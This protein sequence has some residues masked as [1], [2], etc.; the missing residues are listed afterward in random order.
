MF[1]VNFKFR[2]CVSVLD[3]G[4]NIDV[5]YCDIMKAFDQVPIDRLLRKVKSYGIKGSLLA[6]IG[7]F[8]KNRKMSVVINGDKSSEGSVTSG[9]PQGSIL[10]PLLFT[11][12]IND[13]PIGINSLL[14]MFADDTKL[15]REIKNEDDN[16]YLQQD[17]D[18][19]SDWSEIWKLK[20]HPGKCSVLHLGKTNRKTPYALNGQ[21]L[22]ASSSEKDLGVQIDDEL[23]FD[24]HIQAKTSKARQIWGMIRRSFTNIDTETF[25]LL[26]KALVRPHL[27]YANCVWSPRFQEQIDDIE[28]VQRSAT[29]Q[30]PGLQ[31]MTYSE[32]LRTLK[33]PTLKH[34]RRR[35][36]LVE[37]YKIVHQLYDKGAVPELNWIPANSIT[38]GHQFRM[39]PVLSRTKLGQSRFTSRKVNDWNS[40]PTDIVSASSLNS[41]KNQL[42]LYFA[43]DPSVYNV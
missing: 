27:E 37:T 19:L 16:A 38:R 5:I 33:L 21:V 23:R 32:R 11:I 9:V 30:V 25:P 14:F 31:S 13:M 2:D 20:F 7:S 18:K 3:E 15:F 22:Q 34:R 10:G 29:K 28:R 41:F 6:W 8:L 36:D 43:D 42:D 26:F 39:R 24:K 4:G 40:L 12:Y 17:L 1:W 35:G